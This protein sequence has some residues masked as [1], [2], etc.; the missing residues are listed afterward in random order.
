[1]LYDSGIVYFMLY[2]NADSKIDLGMKT[3]YPPFAVILSQLFERW[4][5]KAEII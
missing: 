4:W 2:K 1:M 5:E 3:D